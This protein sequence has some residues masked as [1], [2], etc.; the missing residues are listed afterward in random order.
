MAVSAF[1]AASYNKASRRLRGPRLQH[2]VLSRHVAELDQE[3]G[4]RVLGLR[5][6]VGCRQPQSSPLSRSCPAPTSCATGH[7]PAKIK[8][9]EWLGPHG[10][11]ERIWGTLTL[12]DVRAYSPNVDLAPEDRFALSGSFLQI[13]QVSR[14]DHQDIDVNR[15]RTNLARISRPRTRRYTHAGRLG[16]N[17]LR[18]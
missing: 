17:E 10:G 7:V 6:P 11:Q 9:Y 18:R 5:T 3:A 15:D 14:P 2:S 8:L 1:L 4:R 16:P 13:V 12:P